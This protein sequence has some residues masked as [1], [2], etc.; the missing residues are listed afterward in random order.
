MKKFRRSLPLLWFTAILLAAAA[1][2]KNTTPEFIGEQA[3]QYAAEVMA[4]GPRL[5]GST[6]SRATADYIKTELTAFGWSVGFQDFNHKGVELRNIVARR[7]DSP[8]DV[9]IGAHYD[10]RAISDQETDPDRQALPVP[11]ANDGAS[12]TAILLEFGRAFRNEQTNIWLVFFD[13]EDQ[14]H[15]NDWDWSVGA[16][17]FADHL[18]QKPSAVIVVDMIGDSDLNVYKEKQS[19]PELTAAIWSI[20]QSS[21]YGAQIIDTEKYAML[22]DHLPFIKLGIP[23][24]LMIDFDYPYWHTRADTLDKISAGSLQKIGSTLTTW[25]VNHY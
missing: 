24:C 9:I 2:M 4:F 22:D 8:P 18:E 5:P 11:G 23:A 13:G 17:Y 19:D 1:C 15:L 7:N 6:A 12:G 10:T 14:G 16:Q 21:G 20:A 25:L 3:L